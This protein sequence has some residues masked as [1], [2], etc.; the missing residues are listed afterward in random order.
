MHVS[1]V[2]IRSQH[3]QNVD[4]IYVEDKVMAPT[5]RHASILRLGVGF[6]QFDVYVE[7]N[8]WKGS[9]DICE[10]GPTSLPS[11]HLTMG[12]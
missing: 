10:F 7:K 9:A 5:L 1:V 2:E 12:H 8:M 4:R 3:I 6:L 11:L